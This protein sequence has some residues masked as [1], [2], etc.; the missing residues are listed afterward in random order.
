MKLISG[1]HLLH[2][3]ELASSGDKTD[4][5]G[6]VTIVPSGPSWWHLFY[7]ACLG[8]VIFYSHLLDS[9]ALGSVISANAAFDFSFID[10]FSRVFFILNYVAEGMCGMYT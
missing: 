3:A 5:L 7:I 6:T 10:C 4:K 1:F 2:L 9:L 8:N